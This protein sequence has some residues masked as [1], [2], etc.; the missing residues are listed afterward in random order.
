MAHACFFSI[1]Y[2]FILE[3]G[4]MAGFVDGWVRSLSIQDEVQSMTA[5]GR[6][7]VLFS[8]GNSKLVPNRQGVAA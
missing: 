3:S 1:A 7:V 6:S 5:P 2:K 4:P 8:H